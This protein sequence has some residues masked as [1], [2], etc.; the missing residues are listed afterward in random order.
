MLANDRHG[1]AYTPPAAS[2]LDIEMKSIRDAARDIYLLSL[3]KV[4]VID[5]AS[6]FGLLGAFTRLSHTLR[7]HRVSPDGG[8]MNCSTKPEGDS[9]KDLVYGWSGLRV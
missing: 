2:P 1:N 4:H 5:T 6:G 3:A 9:L 8:N 7:I